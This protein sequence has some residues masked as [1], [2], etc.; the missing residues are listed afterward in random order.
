MPKI[1][2]FVADDHAIVREGLRQVIAASGD[3]EL[4]GEAGD[5]ATAIREIRET[6]PDVAILDIGM[7]VISGLECIPQI[8]SDLPNT[9]IVILSMFTRDTFVHKTLADGGLG[10]VLKSDPLS[11]VV[12][13]VRMVA[14]GR[15]FLS[16]ELDSD[17]IHSLMRSEE[18]KTPEQ[19][20]YEKLSLREQQVFRLVIE[21]KTTKDIAAILYLSPK[22]VEK[23][24]GNI[25]RKL[26]VSEP[27][28]LLKLAMKI[29]VAGPDL[30]PDS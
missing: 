7:P 13:A 9:A 3:L 25:S 29:G 26:G 23:H 11:E 6:R 30:W 27:L 24:R 12:A 22:T 28:A 1:T 21:G 5:G 16:R 4:V 10:Y 20:R 18:G 14:R 2:V 15:Y 8:K 19:H 17:I